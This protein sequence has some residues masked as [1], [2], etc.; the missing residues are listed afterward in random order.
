MRTMRQF[1]STFFLLL[2]ITTSAFAQSYPAQPIRLIVP[3]APGSVT[4]V[5]M[6]AAA[7]KLGPSLGQQIVIENRAGANFVVG[8]QACASATPDGYTICMVNN[9]SL[10]INPLLYTRLPYDA[11]NDFT[12]ITNLFLLV[13]AIAV[14]VSLPVSTV[15][16]LRK[17]AAEKPD[18]LNFGTLGPGSYPDLFLN[19]LNRQWG[20]KMVG[21]PYRGGGPVSL[22]VAAAEVQ[23]ASMGLGNFIGGLEG[24]KVKVLAVSTDDRWAPM[25]N[26]QTYK[27]AGIGHFPGH[28]WWGLVAPKGMP[29]QIVKRL[30]GEFV[31]LFKDPEFQAYL[32]SQAV[33]PY[34]GTPE[35]FAAFLR[36]DKKDA[37]T[38]VEI[39]NPPKT[40]FK[41]GR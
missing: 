6:R 33:Q 35:E 15:G 36:Q 22:A 11:D 23:V 14:P 38:L 30:N 32:R 39:A 18:L 5:I 31:R 20:T 7:Q 29:E 10:S 34:A 13:E 12:P 1:F 25:P 24:G 3:I 41:E 8:A 28:V 16:E 17:L 21:I 9:N 27:E 19:W 26:I 4:D 40:E 2:A 37:A